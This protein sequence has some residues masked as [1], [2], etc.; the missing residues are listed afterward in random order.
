[1]I[2]TQEHLLSRYIDMAVDVHFGDEVL[3][4]KVVRAITK[5]DGRDVKVV[6]DDPL[7]YGGMGAGWFKPTQVSLPGQAGGLGG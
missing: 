7:V 3:P 5:P 2:H 1:M 6:F 4:G